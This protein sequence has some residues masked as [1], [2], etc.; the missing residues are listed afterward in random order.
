MPARAGLARV[1][2]GNDPVRA[3]DLAEGAL[4]AS[5]G[6]VAVPARLAAGWVLLHRGDRPRAARM[7]HLGIEPVRYPVQTHEISGPR[8]PA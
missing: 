6:L 8:A 1:L 7:L 2:A 3:L 4:A 5:D